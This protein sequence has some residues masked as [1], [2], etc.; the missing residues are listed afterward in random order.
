MTARFADV[1]ME[2]TLAGKQTDNN[3]FKAPEFTEAAAAAT[4]ALRSAGGV[5]KVTAKQARTRYDYLKRIWKEWI[6]HLGSI[7]GWG[8]WTGEPEGEDDDLPAPPSTDPEKEEEYFTEHEQ[9]RQFQRK[10]PPC[11]RQCMEI[12]GDRLPTGNHAENG[13]MVF[14]SSAEEASEASEGGEGGEGG[15][16]NESAEGEGIGTN[17]STA[18]PRLVG[19]QGPT[20]KRLAAKKE[21]MVTARTTTTNHGSLMAT[22]APS[23]APSGRSART[24]GALTNSTDFY[25]LIANSQ[26][27]TERQLDRLGVRRSAVG[28]ALE[29]LQSM[30]AFKEAF[31][32]EERMEIVDTLTIYKSRADVVA[33]MDASDLIVY[34][35]RLLPKPAPV[36]TAF[37]PM[38]SPLPS[39]RPPIHRGYSQASH[40]ASTAPSQLVEQY[41][42]PYA[43]GSQF[44]LG[45][46]EW[47]QSQQYYGGGGGGDGRV[48]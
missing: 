44:S 21:A 31:S 41:G 1:L 7:S 20:K 23:P 38:P 33:V 30:E 24:A 16:E 40:Q 10:L 29:R 8:T 27:Q 46:S 32:Q 19:R 28:E 5:G 12:F 34:L 3:G 22:T 36:S 15:S 13:A 26:K 25:S 39:M 47:S 43:S 11:Y 2:A 6:R 37:S 14:I 9:R 48:E 17:R 42:R 45:P 18:A 35:R 4:R